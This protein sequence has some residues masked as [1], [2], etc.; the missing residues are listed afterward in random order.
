MLQYPV[1]LR[2]DTNGSILV[3]APDLP[4]VHTFGEDETEA[5][6]QA[7]D[8]IETALAMYIDDRREIPAPSTGKRGWKYV[9]LPVGTEIKLE[10]YRTM[11]K[12][13]I[14]KAELARRMN[15][16]LPQIDRLLDLTHNSRLDQ[17]E[18]AFLVMGKHLSISA[19]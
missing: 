16:H 11:R 1:K 2:R 4:E 15:C 7:R 18:A 12:G 6:M 13:R 9:T 10:L 8:A 3:E 17:L 14:G 5:L 19:A